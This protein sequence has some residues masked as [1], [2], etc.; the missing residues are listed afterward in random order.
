MEIQKLKVSVD[1]KSGYATQ[2]T[3]DISYFK[4]FQ[5]KKEKEIA[6][7]NLQIQKDQSQLVRF[8]QEL[9]NRQAQL[10]KIQLQQ[11]LI[12]KEKENKNLELEKSLKQEIQFQEGM[13]SLEKDQKRIQEFIQSNQEELKRKKVNVFWLKDLVKNFQLKWQSLKKSI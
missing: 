2:L 13:K 1:S 12:E 11:N 5:T 4:N 6:Q 9:E 8:N 3:S 7:L 10:E